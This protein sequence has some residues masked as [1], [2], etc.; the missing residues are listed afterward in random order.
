MINYP[1]ILYLIQLTSNHI[2]I[3]SSIKRIETSTKINKR[4]DLNKSDEAKVDLF[5]YI[6][7][8]NNE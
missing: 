1:E 2:K 3:Q 6:P 4:S 5:L 7:K 8:T